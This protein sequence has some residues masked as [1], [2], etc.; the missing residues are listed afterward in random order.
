MSANRS[1]NRGKEPQHGCISKYKLGSDYFAIRQH[2]NSNNLL[3][4]LLFESFQIVKFHPFSKT[5]FSLQKPE[6]KRLASVPRWADFRLC[7]A[8]CA[9]KS[10]SS[11][12]SGSTSTSSRTSSTS[13]SRTRWEKES[14]TRGFETRPRRQSG[15]PA[16]TYLLIVVSAKGQEGLGITWVVVVLLWKFYIICCRHADLG[17]TELLLFLHYIA[18]TYLLF[19]AKCQLGL[20]LLE[21]F[22]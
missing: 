19:M 8:D 12:A 3:V 18:F 17:I 13:S 16:P 21:L 5:K 1:Q 7:S 4:K 20:E 9:N 14:E 15:R 22:L 6:T 10:P 11:E 2:N